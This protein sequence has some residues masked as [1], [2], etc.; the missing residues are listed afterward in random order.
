[1]KYKKKVSIYAH[2]Q[3]S[4]EQ[5]VE[6][7]VPAQFAFLAQIRDVPQQEIRTAGK[8]RRKQNPERR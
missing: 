8:R 5:T 6:T 1:M 7:E 3:Q 2:R 4:L